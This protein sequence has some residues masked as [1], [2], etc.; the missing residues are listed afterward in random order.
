MQ[1]KP[2]AARLGLGPE[3]E[4][5]RHSERDQRKSNVTMQPRP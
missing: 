4:S 2:M 1:I 5:I 3:A